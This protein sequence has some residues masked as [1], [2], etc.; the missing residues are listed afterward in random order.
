MNAAAC[1]CLFAACVLAAASVA[2]EPAAPAALAGR[3]ASLSGASARDCGV[4]PLRGDLAAAIAC[5]TDATSSG[6]PYRLAVQLQGTDSVIWQGAAR[7]ERGRLWVVF[8]DADSTGGGTPTLSVVPCRGIV[9]AL[10][11][12]EVLDC[13]PYSEAP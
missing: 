12:G 2:G 3:L 6:R 4:F 5:A 1:R 7:D 10:H 13:Q 8:Y 9:F 11:G